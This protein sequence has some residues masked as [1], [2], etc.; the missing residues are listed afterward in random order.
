MVPGGDAAFGPKAGRNWE[1]K[2]VSNKVEC[3][4]GQ[5]MKEQGLGE[6]EAG[7]GAGQILYVL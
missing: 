3:S 7:F 2:V 5:E 1:M 4:K 6:G